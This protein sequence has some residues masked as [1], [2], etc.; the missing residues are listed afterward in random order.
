MTNGVDAASTEGI[1]NPEAF[2][3][4]IHLH[5]SSMIRTALELGLPDEIADSGSAVTEV[6]ERVGGRS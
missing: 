2:T 5:S 6:A 3:A 1:M 4:M